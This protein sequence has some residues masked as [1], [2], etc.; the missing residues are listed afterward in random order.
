[1]SAAFEHLGDEL[2]HQGHVW[3]LA[4]S[5][6][7]SPEGVDFERNIV[8]SPGSVGVVPLLATPD[9]FVVVLVS[10]YRP[11]FDDY[12]LEIPAGMRDVAGEAPADTARRELIEEAGLDTTE[13]VP[14]TQMKPSPGMTD[15]VCHIF[16]AL[17]CREVDN[18]L[19]GPEEEHLEVVR[20]PLREAIAMVEAGTITDAKTVVGLLLTDRHVAAAARP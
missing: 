6:F 11:P 7:R 3:N 9:G 19:Q 8:R 5:R 16:A 15:A 18:D 20:L 13:L 2:V 1:M 12:V 4:T 10:Q 14:I 17:G